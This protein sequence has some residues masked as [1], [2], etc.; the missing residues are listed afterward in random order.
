[1]RGVSPLIAAVLLIAISVTIAGIVFNWGPS[2][3]QS[4]T[5]RISNKTE[6]IVGCNPPLIED[7]YLDFQEN[8]SRVYV[9]GSQGDADVAE[10]KVIS[11]NGEEAPLVNSSSVP[12][13]ISA[14]KLKILVFNLTGKIKSCSG[15]SQALITSCVTDRFSEAP[16]CR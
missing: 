13:N 7:V 11:T 10:A 1:M 5:V 9:R 14:G 16:K 6:Q 3:V 4:G 2:L 12:F 8:V 15:F